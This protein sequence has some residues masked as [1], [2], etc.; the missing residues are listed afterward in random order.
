[1]YLYAPLLLTLICIQEDY[2]L[3]FTNTKSL[4]EYI[5][6]NAEALNMTKHKAFFNSLFF[7]NRIKG[8]RGKTKCGFSC[9]QSFSKVESTATVKECIISVLEK[10]ESNSAKFKVMS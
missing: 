6:L 7:L 3:P 4:R 9:Q 1:M 8:I 5:K 2:S 10:I